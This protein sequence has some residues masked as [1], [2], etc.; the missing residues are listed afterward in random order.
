MAG[1]DFDVGVVGGGILGLAF[2]WE[3]A[4]RGRRV[5]VFERDAHAQ[6]ATVRNFGM[7]WP[8]G[9]P[10]GASYGLALRSLARWHEL[11]R[12]TGL[13]LE[14]CGSLHLAY[15]AAEEQ[16]LREYAAL[17]P[18]LGVPCEYWGA[19][20]TLDRHPLV[21]PAWLR[22]ALFSA[23]EHAVDP[24]A[25]PG[26]LRDHLARAHGVA[27]HHSTTITHVEMPTLR[28]AS[29]ETWRVGRALVCSGSDFATLFPRE[30]AASGLRR[31]K[32]HMM[33]T[34]PQPGGGRLGAHV[35]GGLTLAHYKAFEACPSLPELKA[36][37]ATHYPEHL[38]H[39]IHVMAAQNAL[40]EVVI[41]DSHEFDDAIS[42][43]DAV[44]I[45]ELILDYLRQLLRLPDPTIRR[46]WTGI[47][48]KH[49][50]RSLTHLEPQP[51]C[52]VVS[53]VGGAGMT[54][55]FGHAQDWWDAHD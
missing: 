8:I 41:G 9:Q 45:D 3:A 1:P 4:R 49:P 35:A 18:G 28:A 24:R 11:A 12:A 5:A 17:A 21:N 25:V 47:Y 7:L 48:A 40:G 46:R 29:G 6:G 10:P 38:G 14:P 55:S 36:W 33:A 27:F 44:P 54:L 34:G 43:F 22:G 13:W 20:R 42:P 30:Y 2:A 26:A 32:L 19:D 52:T 23:A 39:G 50:T 51:G 31:C 53:G 37:L 15:H 16:V